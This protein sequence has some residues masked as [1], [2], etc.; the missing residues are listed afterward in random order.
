MS[1]VV[2]LRPEPG[3]SET[4]ARARQLGLEPILMP[5]FDVEP[6]EWEAPDPAGFDALLV[7]SANAI[8]CGGERLTELRTLP[9][10]AVGEAT[11]QAARDAGFEVATVGEGG[12][13][14]LLDSLDPS[15]RLLHLCGE[16]WREPQAPRQAVTPLT[17]YRSKERPH[18]DVSAAE[19]AIVLMHSPRAARRFAEL[20]S[21][22]GSTSIAAISAAAAEAAGNGWDHVAI[23]EQPND[24]ALLALAARLCNKPA[25]Q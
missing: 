10:H 4:A 11:A 9:A 6:V 21:E 2:V 25:P 13:D 7:T 8:R 16:D 15:M 5:L 14:E 18:V 17:V 3:A 23:A 22:R 12:V 20:S 19:G 1:R 24:H